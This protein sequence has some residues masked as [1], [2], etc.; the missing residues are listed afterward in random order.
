MPR[1]VD[2]GYVA[3]KIDRYLNLK[4]YNNAATKIKAYFVVYN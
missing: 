3:C 1:V 4:S 2:S